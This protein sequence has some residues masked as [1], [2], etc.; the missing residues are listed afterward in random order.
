LLVLGSS[1][2]LA[3][4]RYGIMEGIGFA[5]VVVDEDMDDLDVSLAAAN[6]RKISSKMSL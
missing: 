6:T 5:V 2:W 1:F 4:A 3:L